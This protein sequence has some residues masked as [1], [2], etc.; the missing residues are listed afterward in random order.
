LFDNV[1]TSDNQWA[2]EEFTQVELKDSRLNWRCQEL[3]ATLAQ[4]SDV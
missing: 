1:A 2:S 4:Q 3:A